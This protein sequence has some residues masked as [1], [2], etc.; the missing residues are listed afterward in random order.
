MRRDALRHP[1][2]EADEPGRHLSADRKGRLLGGR[3]R[4]R[5][6]DDDMQPGGAVAVPGAAEVVVGLLPHGHHRQFPGS[7]RSCRTDRPI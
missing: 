1:R 6:R 3:G 7:S 4:G 5:R 2:V